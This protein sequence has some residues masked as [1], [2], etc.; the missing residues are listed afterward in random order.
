MHS[1]YL[2][3]YTISIS[4]FTQGIIVGL[5]AIEITMQVLPL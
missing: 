3:K 4:L 1:K 2:Q 5:N